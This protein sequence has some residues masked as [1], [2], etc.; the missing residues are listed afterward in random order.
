MFRW[1]PW[2]P[3]FVL[4]IACDAAAVEVITEPFLGVRRIELIETVPRPLYINIIEVDLTEPTLSF[5]VSPRGP[6]TPPISGGIPAETQL[7]STRSFLAQENGQLAINASFFGGSYGGGWVNNLGLAAS[8]GDGYSPW[9][10]PYYDPDKQF[11]DA[12]NITQTNIARMVAM[13]SSIATGFETTPVV[14]LY[15]AVTG[16]HRLVQSGTVNPDNNL[17][18]TTGS[19][20]G[21]NPR[22]AVGITTN[23]GHNNN[24]K[25]LMVTVDGRQNGFS[26]GM[27]LLELANL[28]A[29]YGATDAI[30]LD[31]GGSTSMMVNYHGD[32]DPGGSPYGVRQMNVPI[33]GSVPGGER[34]VGTSLAMF[35]AA[36]PAFTPPVQPSPVPFG[37]TVLESFE[38]NEGRFTSGPTASGSTF[39]VSSASLFDRVI[40]ESYYGLG[41]QRLTVR[42]SN[43]G[44]P[45][46]GLRHLSGGGVPA[47][48]TSFA[49]TGHIGFFMKVLQTGVETGDI[50]ASLLI[51]DG[52][53]TEQSLELDVIADGSWHLYE[54]DLDDANQ[55]NNFSGGNGQIDASSVTL[56]SLYLSSDENLN[57]NVFFDMLVHNPGGDLSALEIPAVDPGQIGDFDGDEDVDGADFLKWQRGQ[58]PTPL[59]DDDLQDWKDHFGAATVAGAPVPE[60]R[61]AGLAVLAAV[62]A[63]AAMRAAAGRSRSC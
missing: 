63:A 38:G 51:D 40:N 29:S 27:T 48:N 25:L 14:P 26:E 55:W 57:F 45:G 35:A 1:L 34:S 16:S 58:S 44:T 8:D 31:G 47:N 6:G 17:T 10:S 59:S 60:P 11:D 53:G 22:T 2:A 12:L 33:N 39:G 7:Q 52:V 23:Y 61:S 3:V 15:N 62:M 4:L 32:L 56:D 13:P 49:S 36:N 50:Q 20:A 54:W 5:R 41:S 42:T 18:L 21:L 24:K 30:N 46:L 9:E 43:P 28:M 19:L 37:Y